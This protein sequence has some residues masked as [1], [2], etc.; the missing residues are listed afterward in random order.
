[1]FSPPFKLVGVQFTAMS[2]MN[3]Q[4]HFLIHK[5]FPFQKNI[6]HASFMSRGRIVPYFRWNR[7]Y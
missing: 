1:M 6:P 7:S 5:N 3:Y 4:M 2:I